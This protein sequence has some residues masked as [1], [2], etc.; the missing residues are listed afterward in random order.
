VTATPTPTP[1]RTEA[2]LTLSQAVVLL[3]VVLAL[4]VYLLVHYDVFGSSSSKIT[5]GS[6]AAASAARTVA[7]FT[8]V[9]LAGSNNVVIRVGRPQ[10]V[11]VRADTNLLNRVTTVVRDGRLVIGNMSGSFTTRSPMSV[12]ITA[13]KLDALILS[14]SGNVDVSGLASSRLT[15]KLLGSGNV[16]ASGAARTLVVTIVGSGTA[17]L[18]QLTARDVQATVSGSG[19]IGLTAI[20]SLDARIPGSGTIF[21]GGNPPHLLTSVT[22]SGAITP[23]P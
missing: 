23:T 9:E 20:D 1:H 12:T 14:G 11:T 4:V 10:S 18:R 22:G 15:V 16:S 2:R 3:A 8:G 17:Q 21:Y 5:V 13:P 19:E 6:G 7:P